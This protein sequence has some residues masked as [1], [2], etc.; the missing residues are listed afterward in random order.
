MIWLRCCFQSWYLGL[1]LFGTIDYSIRSQPLATRWASY[2][3]PPLLLSVLLV[4]INNKW[5]EPQTLTRTRILNTRKSHW[6]TDPPGALLGLMLQNRTHQPSTSPHLLP[7]AHPSIVPF[8]VPPFCCHCTI[9]TGIVKQHIGWRG[10]WH[11]SV[12]SFVQCI[13]SSTRSN[14]YQE[15]GSFVS[16]SRLNPRTSLLA[17]TRPFPVP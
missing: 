5:M 9:P 16:L 15:S 13:S 17:S 11:W 12:Y 10:C 6:S 2:S 14:S 7:L 4:N 1:G 3:V 8:L